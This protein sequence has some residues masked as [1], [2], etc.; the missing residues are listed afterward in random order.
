M[1]FLHPLAAS[2][3]EL[4]EV[5]LDTREVNM[6]IECISPDP[7]SFPGVDPE[8]ENTSFSVAADWTPS[9]A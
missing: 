8:E 2:A 1:E 3:V 7:P 6:E 9:D 5:L 4:G